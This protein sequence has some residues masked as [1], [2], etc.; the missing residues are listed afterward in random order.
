M[1]LY[2]T[3]TELVG[4]TPLMELTQYE[5]KYGFGGKILA[6]LEYF[7]PLGSA[8]DRVGLA[9]IEDAERSGAS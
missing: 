8:K 9:M 4:N 1:P 7:N 2:H 3:L 5:K 6:K